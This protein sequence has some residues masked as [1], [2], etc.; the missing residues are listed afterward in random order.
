M[1]V[2]DKYVLELTK[3]F[4]NAYGIFSSYWTTMFHFKIN[5]KQTICYGTIYLQT[6]PNF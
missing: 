1:K 5:W 3:S 6:D 2:E 4:D